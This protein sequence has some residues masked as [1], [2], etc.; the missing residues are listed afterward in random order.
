MK[1][2]LCEPTASTAC[3]T[4]YWKE[5]PHG[6]QL[7]S[8]KQLFGFGPPFFGMIQFRARKLKAAQVQNPF[9]GGQVAFLPQ[10]LTNS[11]QCKNEPSVMTEPNIEHINSPSHP[12]GFFEVSSHAS[13]FRAFQ[14]RPRFREGLLCSEMGWV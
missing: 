14:S 2:R 9:V 4:I 13:G 12:G 10:L 11:A 3:L 5:P 7:Q 6:A 8:C 1:T